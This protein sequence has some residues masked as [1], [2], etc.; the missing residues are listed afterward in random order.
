MLTKVMRAR[1]ILPKNINSRIRPFSSFQTEMEKFDFTDKL[2][3]EELGLK[4]PTNLQ[5]MNLF[6]SI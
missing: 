2:N 5:D 6:S 3:P 4:D 1:Q